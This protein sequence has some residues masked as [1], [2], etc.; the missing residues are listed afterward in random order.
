[1]P[2]YEIALMGLEFFE[3]CVFSL[4]ISHRLGG[5]IISFG[6]LVVRIAFTLPNTIYTG[7]VSACFL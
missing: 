2:A 4:H 5:H 7:R 1:M 3:F 6:R